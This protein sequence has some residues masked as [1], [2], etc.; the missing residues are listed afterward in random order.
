MDDLKMPQTSP[1]LY[2][3]LPRRIDETT[4]LL[5]C[6]HGI[7]RNAFQQLEAFSHQ[8]PDHIGII[9]PLFSKA[10]FKHY[11]Q[12]GYR[13]PE[14]RADLALEES[15]E[16]LARQTGLCVDRFHLF[17]FSGGAQF[18]HRYAMLRPERVKSLHL[19]AAGFYTF[20]D[21][22]MP[23]PAGLRG[24][25]NGRQLWAGRRFFLR[26]P[27]DLYV[28]ELDTRRDRT[29]RKSEL[30][31]CAQGLHRLD[32]AKSWVAHLQSHQ[33]G[34]NQREARLHV[35]PGCSHDFG[36]ATKQDTGAL[37]AQVIAA[38]PGA[39]PRTVMP[40]TGTGPC[41]HHPTAPGTL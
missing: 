28:G 41:V 15:L 4:Q 11:Q 20:L 25:P 24:A 35:L 26:L 13:F 1:P 34:I 12:L 27:I 5:V 3:H 30:L 8:V 10:R 18:A 22:S 7:G 40:Y 21:E 29:L 31:D 36:Q 17:G 38:L 2:C 37:A 19:A 6:V 9:A 14:P 39:N 23:W 32:R 16:A 33:A